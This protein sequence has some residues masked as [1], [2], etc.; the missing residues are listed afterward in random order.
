M[1]STGSAAKMQ[2]IEA[3]IEAKEYVQAEAELKQV[4]N[5][6]YETEAELRDHEK[7]LAT[8]GAVYRDQAYG[9]LIRA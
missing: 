6:A 4:L 1:T 8:L 2:S 3:L 5:N 9:F 7:A